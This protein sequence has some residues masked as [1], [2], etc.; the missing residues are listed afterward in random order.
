MEWIRI[1]ASRLSGVFAN[2]IWEVELDTELRSHRRTPEENCP[3][4]DE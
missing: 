3:P 4:R 1:L 2:G